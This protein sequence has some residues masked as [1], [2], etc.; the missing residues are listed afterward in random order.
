L[1]TRTERDRS[2]LGDYTVDVS[3]NFVSY[4]HIELEDYGR[5]LGVLKAW[6]K[7]EVA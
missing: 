3:H 5:E 4:K 7:L 2:N 6:E 1:L